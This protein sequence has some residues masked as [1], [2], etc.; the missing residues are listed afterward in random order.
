MRDTTP[1][2]QASSLAIVNVVR[3]RHAVVAPWWLVGLAAVAAIALATALSTKAAGGGLGWAMNRVVHDAT[4]SVVTSVPV[5]STVH[6]RVAMSGS[7]GPFMGSIV[8]R[9]WTTSACAGTPAAESAALA[10]P[11]GG[12]IEATAFPYTT[13]NAGAAW[14]TVSYSGDATYSAGGGSCFSVAFMATPT[15]RLRVHDDFHT[16]VTTVGAGSNVHSYV[17][18][19]GTAGIP[20]GTVTI[21][22]WPTADCTGT[23][24]SQ[25][26][27]VANGVVEGTFKYV[28][29]AGTRTF[30]ATYNGN[31]SYTS[32][33]STCVS[34]AVGKIAPSLIMS[35]HDFAFL[36]PD[37]WPVGTDLY[38]GIGVTGSSGTPTGNVSIRRHLG[39]GC[40]QLGLTTSQATLNASGQ[41]SHGPWKNVNPGAY[42]IQVRY[43]GNTTYAAKVACKNYTMQKATLSIPLYAHNANHQVVPS[44]RAGSP[45]HLSSILAAPAGTPTGTMTFLR[46]ANTD[47]TGTVVS[48]TVPLNATGVVETPPETLKVP[49]AWG[50]SASYSGDSR[51]ASSIAPCETFSIVKAIAT[52]SVTLHSGLH[53]VITQPIIGQQVHAQID[54]SGPVGVPGGTATW[55]IWPTSDC[56]GT[57]GHTASGAI[58]ASGIYDAATGYFPQAA[59]AHSHKASYSG[60]SVYEPFTGPCLPVTVAKATPTVT[61]ALH[62]AAHQ[63]ITTT[64]VEAPI[65][66]YTQVGGALGT[67]SGS[68]TFRLYGGS[69]CMGAPYQVVMP[70]AGGVAHQANPLPPAGAGSRSYK[71]LYAGD[72]KYR[73]A[74]STCVPYTVVKGNP[75]TSM[76]IHDPAHA[77][78]STVVVGTHIHPRVAVTGLAAIPATGTVTAR[79]YPQSDCTGFPYDYPT[80]TLAGGVADLSGGATT[81]YAT[82]VGLRFTYSGDANWLAETGPC[83]TLAIT[84]ATPSLTT[85]VHTVTHDSGTTVPV[86]TPVHA[87]GTLLG[88]SNVL[89]SGTMTFRWY[90]NASC[91]GLIATDTVAVSAL[92]SGAESS[93]F[94]QN[95]AGARSVRAQYSGS[96]GYDAA[97]GACVPMTFT[98][99]DGTLTLAVHSST[100]QVVTA[101]PVG[102]LIHPSASVAGSLVAPTGGLV[103][104]WYG[105]PDCTMDPKAPSAGY[106]VSFGPIDATDYTAGS[107]GPIVGS[108][109]AVWSGNPTYNGA[110]LCA[111]FAFNELLPSTATLTIHDASHQGVTDVL[112]GTTVHPRV[113]VTGTGPNAGWRRHLQLVRQ[114][115][116][117][118]IARDDVA[119][120]RPVGRRRRHAARSPRRRQSR[121]RTPSGRS[122]PAMRSTTARRPPARR[123]R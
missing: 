22:S 110:S 55:Q 71:A 18:L 21:S 51:Y 46:W 58:T 116:V 113:A 120:G 123:S 17:T 3:I 76:L 57:V 72:T 112:E 101:V 41:A 30:R 117:R 95:A 38:L 88:V 53:Q 67:P 11:I 62:N 40:I 5:G 92:I 9:R 23:G 50:I 104:T 31:A 56:S 98:K 115:D 73:D 114:R 91:A 29:T 6:V 70:L 89:F 79:F 61:A 26:L 49:Q 63:Q 36:M 82:V 24:S 19:S 64:P 103:F 35:V 80:G 65:H 86:G 47:C 121:A 107:A 122:T 14:F 16:E 99:I 111:Q 8:I 118:G 75:G 1:P 93:P 25:T 7:A 119:A 81:H 2:L 37:N 84:K 109:K 27:P 28:H 77:T 106:A 87:R 68:V 97:T 42:S 60:S 12:V 39:I 74:E 83:T 96:N 32:V 102:S 59:G 44:V 20:T 13:T 54:F 48:Q 105:S 66:A 52:G 10:V 90:G 85:V 78:V 69:S 43:N 33:T 94:T 45:F 4:H 108:V 34:I 15:M 100:H